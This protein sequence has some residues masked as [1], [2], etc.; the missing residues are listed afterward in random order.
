MIK[1]D[2]GYP[3][4]VS[5]GL[6]LSALGSLNEIAMAGRIAGR[7]EDQKKLLKTRFGYLRAEPSGLKAISRVIV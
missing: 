1:F 5:L 2:P 3:F 7:S 4:Y 6:L